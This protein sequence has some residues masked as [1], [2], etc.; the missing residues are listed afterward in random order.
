MFNFDPS[1]PS[2]EYTLDLNK[3]FEKAT[4]AQLIKV[5]QN[6]GGRDRWCEV[7]ISLR[8]RGISPPVCPAKKCHA[9]KKPYICEHC[10]HPLYWSPNGSNFHA[11]GKEGAKP[12]DWAASALS[13]KGP[14]LKETTVTRVIGPDGDQSECEIPD[15]CALI[16][17]VM[18]G[19]HTAACKNCDEPAV[20]EPCRLC[21]GW[22]NSWGSIS[23]WLDDDAKLHDMCIL[24]IH[25]E[26]AQRPATEDDVV[27]DA[28][29]LKLKQIIRDTRKVRKRVFLRQIIL[30]MIIL[31]RQARDKHRENSKQRRV[32]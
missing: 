11:P 3:P 6:S 5:V 9:T 28:A 15:I 1:K 32:F 24:R 19:G 20:L 31:P 30:K 23:T 21:N 13:G 27:S 22:N 14:E 17:G 12:E 8:Y 29:L 25:H 18:N 7:S 2:G 4:V 26:H 10:M 16:E